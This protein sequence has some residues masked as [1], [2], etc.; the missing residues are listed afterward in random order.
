[1]TRSRRSW[2]SGTVRER[3]EGS[4]RWQLRVSL[5]R[6]PLTLS[7]RLATRTVVAKNKTE[8]LAKLRAFIREID[9]GKTHASEKTVTDL[10]SEYADHQRAKRRSPTTI[11]ETERTRDKVI[12][13]LGK[14]KLCDLKPRHLDLLYRQLG[15]G[16]EDHRAQSA[17]SIQRYHAVLS[18]ALNY[19]VIQEWLPQNPAKRATGR[20][21]LD[22][23]I[24]SIP[25]REQVLSYL[26]RAKERDE[27]FWMATLL[28][29]LTAA[30]RGEYCALKWSD[31]DA[32]NG[33]VRIRRSLYRVKSERGEKT[34]KG[35][36]ERWVPIN[37]ELAVI[38][39]TWR[40]RCE[41]IATEK[42]TE[43]SIDAYILSRWPDGSRPINPDTLSS[44]QGNLAKEIGIKLEG[45]NP[46]RHFGG[47]EILAAGGTPREGAA[48]LGHADPAFFLARYTHSTTEREQLAA[49]ALGKVLRPALP[50]G[51]P[52]D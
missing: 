25:T 34:T 49:A 23:A 7:P 32:D 52:S 3:P 14:V 27:I 1:M 31:I 46:F 22:H 4:H 50:E 39:I 45:R 12:G 48:I 16:D 17:S 40:E 43:L 15:E 41:A 10:L 47:S 51:S 24:I 36:R 5:G 18:S 13:A 20:P 44:F 42:G 28:A 35:R 8:A 6:D 11:H 2:G 21:E 30:R 29:I 37:D 9:D 33:V 26:S 38:L 19:A